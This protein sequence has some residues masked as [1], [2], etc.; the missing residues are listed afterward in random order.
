VPLA[1]V[2]AAT[3]GLAAAACAA[4]PPESSAT[5]APPETLARIVTLPQVEVS[6]TRLSDKAP[7]ARSVLDRAA[8]LDR[9]WGQ[10][11]PMARAASLGGSVDLETA[12]FA[13]T[14][15]AAAS[16]S[17]GSFET[18]RLMLETNSGRLAGGWNYYGRYSRIETFGYRD[19][20][21]SKLWSYALSARKLA[22][23]HSFRVNLY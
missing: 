23:N 2:S 15:S 11:T 13:E 22:G 9:N 17:Y 6:T 18:K 14:P 16:V 20:S 5:A 21:W 7:I 10:D 3:I 19:Q 12:P 4:T 1:I 8:L